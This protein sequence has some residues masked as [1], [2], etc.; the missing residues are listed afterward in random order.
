M[1]SSWKNISLRLLLVEALFWALYLLMVVTWNWLS[2]NQLM[3][4]HAS[5]MW[6][7]LVVLLPYLAY[8]FHVQQM[9]SLDL[10]PK[11][12]QRLFGQQP[13][14]SW[15]QIIMNRLAFGCMVIALAQPI[16]GEEST[17][18]KVKNTEVVLT[19][20]L[21]N[22]MNTTDIDDE[23]S[24]LEIVKRAATEL[25]NELKG[26]RIG[27]VIFAGNAYAQLPITKDYSA[28]KLFIQ[29]LHTNLISRQGTNFN[30]ALSTSQ[31]MFQ[32]EQAAKVILLMTDGENHEGY[33]EATLEQ[34]KE[35]GT[36]LMMMGVGTKKGGLVPE[37][38]GER[39]LG[40]KR[41]QDGKVV[42]SK[43]DRE[44]MRKMAESA[45]GS[46][47]FVDNAFP[48]LSTILTE[49]N[50]LNAPKLGAL[51]VEIKSNHFRWP[52]ALGIVFWL[53]GL[54]DKNRFWSKK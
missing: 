12:W 11:G 33:P 54:M 18:T 30:A 20:D 31:K 14:L 45:G 39:M 8:V 47:H 24:R 28:A 19:V 9:A 36:R 42:L 5:A 22:S 37:M 50:R 48:N 41:D 16:Y 13:K 7:Q 51:N 32:N 46:V 25:V 26:E 17:K 44:L 38:A 27:I 53:I 6:F 40:Y 21:S 3:W 23:L 2:E 15:L 4:R 10:S 43:M 1:Q 34:I 35:S 29:D 49:I 52:L